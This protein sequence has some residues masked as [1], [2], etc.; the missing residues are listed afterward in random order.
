MMG[1]AVK[2]LRGRD[3]LPLRKGDIAIIRHT[4]TKLRG[5]IEEYFSAVYVAYG[6]KKPRVKTK[7][8]IDVWSVAAVIRPGWSLNDGQVIGDTVEETIKKA[9]ELREEA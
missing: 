3:M 5:G 1:T 7:A 4:Y 6:G 9:M 2:V 8:P